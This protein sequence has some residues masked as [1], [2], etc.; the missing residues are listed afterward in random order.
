MTEYHKMLALLEASGFAEV[1]HFTVPKL[2][3]KQFYRTKR[4]D[5]LLQKS[6][7]ELFIGGSALGHESIVLFQYDELG[8]LVDTGGA[9]T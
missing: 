6:F 8:T 1:E 5:K 3:F 2:K 7:L 9:E 4:Y